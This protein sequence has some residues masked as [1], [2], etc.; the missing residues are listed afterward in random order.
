M[1]T[2]AL[3][4]GGLENLSDFPKEERKLNAEKRTCKKVTES[5]FYIIN[6]SHYAYNFN[7]AIALVDVPKNKVYMHSQHCGYSLR[8]MFKAKFLGP[9]NS[10]EELQ[11]ARGELEG[12]NN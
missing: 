1:I 4:S 11:D 2:D 12:H 8:A 9:F 10:K 5:G 7:N 3:F 6:G